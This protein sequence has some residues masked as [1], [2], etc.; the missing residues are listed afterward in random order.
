MPWRQGHRPAEHSPSADP[1]QRALRVV[2]RSLRTERERTGPPAWSTA[3]QAP[4]V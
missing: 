1:L 3:G 2:Y 4:E